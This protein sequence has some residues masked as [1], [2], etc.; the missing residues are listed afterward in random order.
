MKVEV[1]IRT[2]AMDL[3]ASLEHELSYKLTSG[4]PES[5]TKELKDCA[6]IISNIDIRMQNLYN[7]TLSKKPDI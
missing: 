1:Q 2:I 6:D 4:K 3:W 7:V 5:V